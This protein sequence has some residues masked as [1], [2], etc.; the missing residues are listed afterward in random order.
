M[1]GNKYLLDLLQ[2]IIDVEVLG[3]YFNLP[4]KAA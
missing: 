2:K 4:K 1:V 3:F